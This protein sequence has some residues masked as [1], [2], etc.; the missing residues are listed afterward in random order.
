MCAIASRSASDPSAKKNN[1]STSEIWV[2]ANVNE[3]SNPGLILPKKP[4][5]ESDTNQGNTM[6]DMITNLTRAEAEGLKTA[7][8]HLIDERNLTAGVSLLEASMELANS[9]LHGIRPVMFQALFNIAGME[10]EQ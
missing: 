4:Y 6:T 8:S 3:D 7:L 9:G 2:S 10:V 5:F 1:K